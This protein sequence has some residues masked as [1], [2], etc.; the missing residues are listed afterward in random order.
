MNKMDNARNTMVS[1]LEQ[2]HKQHDNGDD[3][4]VIISSCYD[5]F[6]VISAVGVDDDDF[7]VIHS[8]GDDN[9]D[10]HY[11]LSNNAEFWEHH[12]SNPGATN[13]HFYR[14]CIPYLL[15][16]LAHFSGQQ[17]S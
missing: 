11:A 1:T 9:D 3:D 17:N 13:N 2:E 10:D 7:A 14:S 8:A 4:F 5:D 15:K 12:F 6:V 16:N